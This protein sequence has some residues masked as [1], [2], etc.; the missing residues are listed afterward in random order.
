MAFLISFIRRLVIEKVCF[1]CTGVAFKRKTY[2]C[3]LGIIEGPTSLKREG[4]TGLKV[5]R[6][7][8]LTCRK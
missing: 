8:E 2:F 1:I 3:F 5:S 4:P 6:K 7:R